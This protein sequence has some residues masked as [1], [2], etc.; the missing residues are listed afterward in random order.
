MQSSI[1]CGVLIPEILYEPH[2]DVIVR[3]EIPEEFKNV[4]S[5]RIVEVTCV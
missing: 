5:I 4:T 2:Y 1:I 3:A